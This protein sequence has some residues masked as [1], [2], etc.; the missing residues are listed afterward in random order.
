VNT[1]ILVIG[2]GIA[3]LSFAI[4][5]SQFA[6][7]T[8]ATKSEVAESATRHAQG[9]LAAVMKKG[10]SCW[11]HVK[12]TLRAGDGLCIK[13]SV[14][15]LVKHAPEQI[16]WLQGLGMRFDRKPSREAVHSRPRIV[17][18]GDITGREVEDFLVS[19]AKESKNI[20]IKEYHL[21]T[22][23]IREGNMVIGAYLLDARKNGIMQCSA[24]AVVLA[25][26]GLGRLYKNTVNPQISTG[27]GF[28]LA[29]NAGAELMDMEFVQF[30]PTGLYNS[31][32]PFL[33]S[34]TVRGEGGIM[35]NRLGM[36]YMAHYH[37]DGDLAPRDVVSKFSIDEMKKTKS[38]CVYLDARHLG[39]QYLKKRFP[40]IYAECQKYGIDMA[41]D[42]IP[43]S[44]TAHYS[45][46]GIKIDLKA[47]TS[48]TNLYAIGENSCCGIHGADRLASNSLTEGLVIGA[49]LSAYLKKSMKKEESLQGS[50]ITDL[51]MPCEPLLTKDKARL[52]TVRKRLQ[53]IMWEQVG[54]IRNVAGLRDAITEIEA[55]EKEAKRTKGFDAGK[56]QALSMLTTA[57]LIAVFALRRKE[58]RG[59]HFLI[60]YPERDDAR[61][62][63]HLTVSKGKGKNMESKSF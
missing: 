55:L 63:R 26:G 46:G 59:T 52:A 21:A 45:C 9:G 1:D 47:R 23:L 5:A 30:H 24:K 27:D 40:N 35:K 12:D 44:P 10:D 60:D 2:S 43:V 53:D 32:P 58:S 15:F 51:T 31:E 48:L 8:I 6:K 62:I 42:M 25:C 50:S 34:E 61:W 4:K 54:I 13:K 29:Y 33:I 41:K 22:K 49:S 38:S 20:T 28:A 39:G 16:R 19:L 11:L 14:N 3:G 18:R 36:P 56:A 57:R 17:H 7:V 37:R